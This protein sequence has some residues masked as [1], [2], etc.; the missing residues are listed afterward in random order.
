MSLNTKPPANEA[1]IGFI[2]ATQMAE[3]LARGFLARGVVTA[4]SAIDRD[5][6]LKLVFKSLGAKVTSSNRDV[7]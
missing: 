6:A 1:R 4:I 2:G 3:A 7:R 5:V